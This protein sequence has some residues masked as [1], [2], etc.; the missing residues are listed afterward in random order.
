MS[1]VALIPPPNSS[2]LRRR[3]PRLTVR[4]RRLLTAVNLHFAGVAA[5]AVLNL[6]LLAHLLFA[7]QALSAS[8][9][10]ALAQQHTLLHAAQI[11]GRPLAGIDGKLTAST[12]QAD[13]FY[14]NRLPYAYSQVL[15][16]LGLLTTH[17]GVRLGRVQYTYAPVLSGTYALTEIRMD[18]SV[19]G[20]YRPVIGMINSLERDRMFFVITGIALTGQQTGQVNLRLRLVA[21]LR[22]AGPGEQA[23]ELPPPSTDEGAVSPNAA[24]T[25]SLGET[26]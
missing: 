9:P 11:A 14:A 6:Y 3:L 25:A 12:E 24:A 10:E 20:D 16:E 5:L 23:G 19:S 21:Y 1:T 22:A 7:W 13:A 4:A 17:A 2:S 15:T 8:G 18:A 26:R